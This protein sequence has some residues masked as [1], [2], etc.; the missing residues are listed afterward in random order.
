MS[1]DETTPDENTIE[2]DLSADFGLY[3]AYM[4]LRQE[5]KKT[6]MCLHGDIVKESGLDEETSTKQLC[7]LLDQKVVR[8]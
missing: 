4:P 8:A 2:L 5:A 6:S 1:Q 7:I 3:K